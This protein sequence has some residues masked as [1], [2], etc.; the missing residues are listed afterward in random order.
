MRRSSHTLLLGLALLA[1]V[2]VPGFG[3][4]ARPASVSRSSSSPAYPARIQRLVE[5]AKLWGRL[6]W[7]HPA[8]ADGQIN[9]DQALVEALPDLEAADTDAKQ[10]KAL[11]TLLAPLKDPSVQ[12]G[13]PANPAWVKAPAKTDLVTW[14]PGDVALVR[15]N[16]EVSP[17]LPGFGEA[18][19][20]MA[21][22]LPKAK[23][24]V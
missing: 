9:W 17:F 21:S 18:L 2:G 19:H 12:V 10:V 6:K 15:L 20:Q 11:Q 22:A 3:H 7:V 4:E 16:H 23:G 24:L 8:L 5:A 13:P 1:P 14:L